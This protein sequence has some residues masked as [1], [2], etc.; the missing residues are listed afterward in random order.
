MSKKPLGPQEVITRELVARS[1]PDCSYDVSTLRL[2]KMSPHT[3]P[4][5]GEYQF[6]LI[7]CQTTT[8]EQHHYSI[9]LHKW[10]DDGWD[11]VS[12]SPAFPEDASE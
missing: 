11:Y 8:G 1:S 9:L 2:L 3:D 5:W 7:G 4:F 10:E 6:H 12:I